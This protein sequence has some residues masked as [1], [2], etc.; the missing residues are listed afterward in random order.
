MNHFTIGT[1]GSKLAVTQ[2]GQ[3]AAELQKA[4]PGLE[5]DIKTIKTTG[6][7]DQKTRLDQFPGLGV[8]V[9]EL[10]LALFKGEIDCAVHSLKDVPEAIPEGLSLVSFPLR[11]DARD[12]FI[13]RNTSFSKLKNGAKI[14]TGSPRRIVQL[15]ALRHDLDFIPVRGNIDTRLKK[16]KEGQFDGLIMAAAG[17]K[18]LG[19][20]SE[21]TRFFSFDE[22]IPAIGQGALVLE[23]RETDASS[24]TTVKAINDNLTEATVLME[25]AFMAAAGGGCR[26]PMACHVYLSGDKFRMMAVI[27]DLKSGKLCRMEHA[28]PPMELESL[29]NRVCQHVLLD[30]KNSGVPVPKDLPPHALIQNRND[31][32]S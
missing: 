31:S 21:I 30:C 32:L 8:F 5:V 7:A 9:K 6:D 29:V 16:L 24:I 19:L 27:G 15:K 17:L 23:C 11:E 12:V 14:G 25:R 3:V 13:S 20:K 10:R 22:V 18:R 1:R 28:E 4:C 2:A 26:V